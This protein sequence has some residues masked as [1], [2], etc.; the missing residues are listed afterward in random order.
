MVHEIV[1]LQITHDG[2]KLITWFGGNSKNDAL[3][4]MQHKST[5]TEWIVVGLEWGPSHHQ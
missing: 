1:Y 5:R 2:V 4:T 3:R